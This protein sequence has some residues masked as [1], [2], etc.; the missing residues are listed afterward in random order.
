MKD[1]VVRNNKWWYN[2][3]RTN[4][5]FSFR[6]WWFNWLIFLSCIF[7]FWWFCP[8][9]PT[10]ENISC[11]NSNINQH[12][13]DITNIIDSCCDCNYE[14]AEVMEEAVDCP[15]REIVIQVCNANSKV[16]DNFDVYLNGVR[17]GKLNLNKND[18]IGSLF[19]AS[20]NSNLVVT[21]PDFQCPINK[22]EKYY[23]NPG[24]LN[25][26]NNILELQNTKNNNNGNA[27]TIQLR[28]YLISGNNLITPCVVADRLY[29]GE[30]GDSFTL[31]FNYTKCCE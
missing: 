14:I 18:Q 27:G 23:F 12:L 22:M 30:T 28:N 16:D 29:S 17:I 4:N 20:T 7:L 21:D 8:C 3:I 26:G 6:Y 2:R 9:T 13:S 25:F 19:I 31:N 24:L 10:E 15:D 11:D 1:R 5:W